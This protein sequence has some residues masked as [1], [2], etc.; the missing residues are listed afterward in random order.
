MK[1]YKS[2]QLDA[3]Y[4]NDKTYID[5][6]YRLKKIATSI[7]VWENLPN[8]MDGRY[9]ELCLFNCGQASLLY[10]DEY[11]FINT[12]AV[13]AGDVNIYGLPTAVNCF[14]Y[15][16]F[17]EVRNVYNGLTSPDSSKSSECILVKNNAD[18]IPTLNTIQL[19]AYRLYEAERTCDI[20]VKNAKRSR[21]ILTSEN[22]RLT[23]ENLFRE[24]DSNI[25]YI[26]G[27]RQNFKAGSIESLDISSTFVGNDIMK[28][29]KEIFNE[30]LTFIGIDNFSDKRERLVTDEVNSNNEVINMN[31]MSFLAPREEACKQFNEKYGENISVSVRS[32]LMNII[33]N[34]ASSVAKEYEEEIK[35]DV[36][37]TEKGLNNE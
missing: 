22:Q 25:P 23:M 8:S 15:G 2:R 19:F 5:Y 37:E 3:I 36:K 33:K 12:K 26:F 4:L 27:D 34:Y 29:K 11:G 1:R 17:N 24:Y 7:F 30:F 16:R 21:L 31:L 13:I 35:A 28:Y 9:L 32:D 10:S 20:A 14:S 6:L 18:C